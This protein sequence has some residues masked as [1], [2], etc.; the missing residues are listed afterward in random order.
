MDSF[1]NKF[2][3]NRFGF[4]KRLFCVHFKNDLFFSDLLVGN[5][6]SRIVMPARV[7]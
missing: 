6:K 7:I 5:V 3:M 1:E 4:L 2:L